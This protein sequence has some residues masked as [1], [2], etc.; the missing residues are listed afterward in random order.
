M[1][2][3]SEIKQVRSLSGPLAVSI[4]LSLTARQR[5]NSSSRVRTV[6]EGA[7]REEEGGCEDGDDRER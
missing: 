4:M 1:D 5:I 7:W 2:I 6:S 3:S